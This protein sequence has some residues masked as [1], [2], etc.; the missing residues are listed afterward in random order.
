[1][2]EEAMDC[3]A[4]LTCDTK[5][6]NEK[7][8]FN[9]SSC[10]FEPIQT[11]FEDYPANGKLFR[12]Y[13]DYKNFIKSTNKSVNPHFIAYSKISSSSNQTGVSS[14][15]ASSLKTTFKSNPIELDYDLEHD[16]SFNSSNLR[17]STVKKVNYKV[18]LDLFHIISI[19]S[20]S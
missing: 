20:D 18:S 13:E 14:L 11:N 8:I 10:L 17:R 9:F 1:M 12:T 16:H 5:I 6:K 2:D 4:D 19:K 7:T 3:K 15:N